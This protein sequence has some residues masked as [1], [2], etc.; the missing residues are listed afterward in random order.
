MNSSVPPPLSRW[1]GAVELSEGGGN[2]DRGHSGNHADG[3]GAPNL[4]F[5]RGSFRDGTLGGIQARPRM[6]EER[7]AGGGEFDAAAVARRPLTALDGR[8]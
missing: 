6:D 4:S 1:V 2:V 7:L 8:R 5:R 3:E